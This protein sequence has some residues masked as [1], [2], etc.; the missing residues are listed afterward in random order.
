MKESDILHE[1]ANLVLVLDNN[2][3]EIRLTGVTHSVVIGYPASAETALQTM[4]R[5]ERYPKNLRAM[6]GHR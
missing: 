4:A 2:R 1:T 5:L 6:Y 3:L